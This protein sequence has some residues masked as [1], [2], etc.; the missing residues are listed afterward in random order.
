MPQT[1]ASGNKN[2]AKKVETKLLEEVKK[3]RKRSKGYRL[4][5][6][7]SAGKLTLR[8][9]EVVLVRTRDE[10]IEYIKAGGKSWQVEKA[11]LDETSEGTYQTVELWKVQPRMEEA[12][13]WFL[14]RF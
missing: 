12:Y 5:K 8:T 1:S 10:A 2:I 4:V 3:A 6:G 11:E 9:D 7:E 13:Y 14:E